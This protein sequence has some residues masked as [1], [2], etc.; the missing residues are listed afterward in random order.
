[1]SK[2]LVQRIHN[3]SQIRFLVNEKKDSWVWGNKQEAKEFTVEKARELVKKIKSPA[4]ILV[5]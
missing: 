4:S 3:P 2:Y 5:I 1:M